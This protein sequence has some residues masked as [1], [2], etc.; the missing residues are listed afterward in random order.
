MGASNDA[1]EAEAWIKAG[2]GDD[3]T[4]ILIIADAYD[5]GRPFT[6][7]TATSQATATRY[8]LAG[9]ISAAPISPV[10]FFQTARAI[11]FF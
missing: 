2:T 5:R 4:D 1:R 10:A 3:K 9:V 8:H 6:A 7:V 11:S